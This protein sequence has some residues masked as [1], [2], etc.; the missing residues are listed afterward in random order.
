[1]AA[2]KVEAMWD[3]DGMDHPV[4]VVE[5]KRGKLNLAELMKDEKDSLAIL[6]KVGEIEGLLLDIAI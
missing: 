3:M 4:L 6:G 5:K 1:M 2:A